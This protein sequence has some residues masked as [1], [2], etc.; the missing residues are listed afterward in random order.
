MGGERQEAV[1]DVGLEGV[2]REELVVLRGVEGGDGGGAA[3]EAEHA[4]EARP[5]GRRRLGGGHGQPYRARVRAVLGLGFGF[6]GRR[7]GVVVAGEKSGGERM[8]GNRDLYGNGAGGRQGWLGTR[9][10]RCRLADTWGPWLVGPT[11]R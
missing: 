4:E 7:E 11:R 3:A 2:E 5:G 10:A 8:V 9:P 6:P 1:G